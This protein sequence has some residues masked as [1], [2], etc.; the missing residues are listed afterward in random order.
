MEPRISQIGKSA[1]QDK[2]IP[3]PPPKGSGSVYGGPEVV[4]L[5]SDLDTC[6]SQR[7]L[8]YI[9]TGVCRPRELLFPN[10][11]FGLLGELASEK[12]VCFCVVS[13]HLESLA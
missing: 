7:F 12:S 3:P 8:G 6:K 1:Q 2:N 9:G 13:H 5:E 11:S 4:A 10:F